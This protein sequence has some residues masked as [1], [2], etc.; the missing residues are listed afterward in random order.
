MKPCEPKYAHALCLLKL[1]IYSINA[2][3]YKACFWMLSFILASPFLID[4]LRAEILPV[5]A[6]EGSNMTPSTPLDMRLEQHC[7]RLRAIYLESLR[8]TSSSSTVR[9]VQTSTQIGDYVVRAGT[10]IFIPYRQMHLSPEVFGADADT[11]SPE[12]FLRHPELEKHPCFKP[13]GGGKTYCPGRFLA[14]KEIMT[15]VALVITRFHIQAA[16]PCL[17]SDRQGGFP[18]IDKKKLSLAIM[19]P[20]PGDDLMVNVK[21]RLVDGF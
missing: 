4:T 20:I 15:F 14:Q 17:Q 1:F 18:R 19:D 6:K 2:N 11:F 9:G 3:A 16:P 7:P 13:F 5:I 12:R 8:M 10:K 21:Q